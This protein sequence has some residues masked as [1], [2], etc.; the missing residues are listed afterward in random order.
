MKTMI[1]P[2][3]SKMSAGIL[4][5]FWQKSQKID[6]FLQK[7]RNDQKVKNANYA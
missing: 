4:S 7:V 6:F 1:W 5:R 2:K 3:S